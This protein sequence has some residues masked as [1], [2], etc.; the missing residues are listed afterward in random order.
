MDVSG[1]RVN[2]VNTGIRPIAG[3]LATNLSVSNNLKPV[4][5]SKDNTAKSD[6]GRSN[7]KAKIPGPI[8]SRPRESGPRESG[9]STTNIKTPLAIRL[10]R[11]VRKTNQKLRWPKPDAGRFGIVFRGPTRRKFVSPYPALRTDV[12]NVTIPIV[13]L[14]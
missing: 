1:P 2:G 11:L 9:P 4:V 13:S 12:A 3:N 6:W 5:K 7:S 10:N 8:E 14:K